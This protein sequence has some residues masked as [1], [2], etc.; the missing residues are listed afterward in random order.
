MF[1]FKKFKPTQ[2]FSQTQKYSLILPGTD[3]VFQFYENQILIADQKIELFFPEKIISFCG[4][5]DRSKKQILLRYVVGKNIYQCIFFHTDTSLKMKLDRGLDLSI[6]YKK[7]LQTLTKKE[8]LILPIQST[9]PQIENNEEICFGSHKKQEL[10]LLLQRKNPKEILPI[11]FSLGKCLPQKKNIETFSYPSIEKLLELFYESF[12]SNVQD[13]TQILQLGY[14]KIR[15]LIVTQENQM[16]HILPTLS[17]MITTGRV[18]N[19]QIDGL[20]KLDI[21][22]KKGNVFQVKIH[23][24][25]RADFYLQSN[26][27]ECRVITARKQKRHFLSDRFFFEKDTIYLFDRFL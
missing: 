25:K 26:A 9:I 11:I 4:V 23:A 16:I 7:K 13:I 10:S 18:K 19:F 22:W 8:T 5:Q 24:Q 3:L 2:L 17:G 1:C 6:K 27:C 20:G 15:E 21:I 14:V 12:S